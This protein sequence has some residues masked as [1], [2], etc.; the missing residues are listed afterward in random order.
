MNKISSIFPFVVGV[1][2]FTYQLTRRK[3]DIFD[4]VF[5]LSLWL[6]IWGV[7]CIMHGFDYFKNRQKYTSIYYLVAVIVIYC[8]YQSTLYFMY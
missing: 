1:I 4:F 7:Y 3:D 5:W 6:I 8:T 2:G